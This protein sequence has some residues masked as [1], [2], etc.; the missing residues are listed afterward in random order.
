MKAKKEVK[1]TF[2]LSPLSDI[3]MSHS[4]VAVFGLIQK[5]QIETVITVSW[6]CGFHVQVEIGDFHIFGMW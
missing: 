2:S 5:N 6:E 3:V 1:P 4:H